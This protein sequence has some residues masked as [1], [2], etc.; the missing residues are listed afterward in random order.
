LPESREPD[1]DF[2]LRPNFII[3]NFV[4]VLREP[5]FYTYAATGAITLAGLLTYVSGSPLLFMEVFNV[6]EKIYGWIFAVLSVGLI[7][8]SN[9]NSLLL[10]RYSSEEIIR[11]ALLMQSVVGAFLCI[12]TYFAVLGLYPTIVLIFLYLC[13]AGFVLPNTSALAMEPF[14]SNAGSASSLMGAGQMGLG[15]LL[16]VLL[17][18]FNDHTAVPMTLVML[19]TAVIGL[20]VLMTGSRKI[21]QL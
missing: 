16:T 6:G 13:C 14:S 18:F 12:G 1:P 10:K 21:V 9:V 3:R 7:G 4:S 11:T 2:S 8:A 17:S 15:A 5:R 20:I 19:F